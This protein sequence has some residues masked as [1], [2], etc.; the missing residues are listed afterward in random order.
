MNIELYNDEFFA[1]HK[2]HIHYDCV[3]AGK[4]IAEYFSPESVIDYGCGIGSF[5][6]GLKECNVN[7]KGYEISKAAKPFIDSSIIEDIEFKNILNVKDYA[8]ISLCLEV[9]EH[10]DPDNSDRLVKMLCGNTKDYIIF[11]AAPPGQ[12]GTGHINCQ[13]KKYWIDLFKKYSWVL[14]IEAIE[15]LISKVKIADYYINNLMIFTK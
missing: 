9:A 15:H 1:W 2:E 8:D 14:D 5:I 3:E 13:S 7:V 10:I 4:F 6:Q 11:T 12:G